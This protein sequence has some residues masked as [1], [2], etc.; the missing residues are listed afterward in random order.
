MPLQRRMPKVGFRSAMKAPRAEV[1]L[2]ELAQGRRRGDRPRGADQGAAWCRGH[3]ERA[4]V[5]LS[6]ELKKAVTLKGVG[7]HQGRARG[8][9]SRRRQDRGLKG[10]LASMA[11]S[12]SS[13]ASFGDVARSG[14]IRGRLLF[15]IGA[16][17][18]YR[19]GTFIPVPGI[20]PAAVARFFSDQLEHAS[21][22]SSTCSPAAR[23]RAC[24]S[25]PWA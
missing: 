2:H 18:V 15:L 14:E 16:L 25:S 24:R 8:D 7:G 9:R 12:A 4:K 17:V 21:S 13:T 19:I 22:A 6:G 5:V 23:C 10:L 1:R 3:A 11:T 20:N